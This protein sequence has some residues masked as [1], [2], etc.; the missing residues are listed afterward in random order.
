MQWY[1]YR[2]VTYIC[3][4]WNGSILFLVKLRD[5]SW[6]IFKIIFSSFLTLHWVDFY[7]KN[8]MI[9]LYLDLINWIF[10]SWSTCKFFCSGD[11]LSK[12]FFKIYFL[13][14]LMSLLFVNG[15]SNWIIF[16]T[17]LRSLQFC[18]SFISKMLYCVSCNAFYVSQTCWQLTTRIDEH[19]GR[20]EKSHIY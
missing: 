4:D 12:A 11:R 16:R 2:F 14:D 17:T 10:F 7:R 8:Q 13:M 20:D 5:F 1:F 15:I 18:K 9:P 3:Y 19:F 6:W